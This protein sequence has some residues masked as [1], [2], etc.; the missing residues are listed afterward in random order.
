MDEQYKIAMK[1]NRLEA[2]D[3]LLEFKKQGDYISKGCQECIANRP[4]EF[5]KHPFYIFAHCR[6][7][8]NGYHKRLIWAPRLTRPIPQTNSM[9]F[10]YYPETDTIKIIWMI[11]DTSLWNQYFSKNV[12]ECEIVEESINIFRFYKELL[13]RK[14]PDDLPDERVNH[15]YEEIKRNKM[16]AKLTI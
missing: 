14:D 11:P 8:D 6:T 13:Q 1:V 3:R 10:K 12:T 7:H 4:E 15:I 5:G 16:A 9:L 2:H